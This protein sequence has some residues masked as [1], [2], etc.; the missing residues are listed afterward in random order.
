[1]SVSHI[2]VLLAETVDALQVQDGGCYVDGT[3]GRGGYTRAIL[4]AADCSV[5]AIDQDPDAIAFGQSLK[6][7]FGDRLILIQGRFGEMDSL[8]RQATAAPIDGVALDIGVSSPQLDS[9]ERGFSFRQDGPLDMRMSASGPTAAD[10]VNT[11]KETELSTIIFRLGEERAARRIAKAI[12]KARGAQPITRTVQLAEIVRSVLP[13]QRAGEND[14][15]TRTFQALRIHVNREL[16][17][18]D[19]GLRSAERLLRAGGRLA[20]VSFH[21]LEDR[22]VKRF[23]RSRSEEAP[24]GSRHRPDSG[25]RRAPTF[26]LL[27]R[28]AIAPSPAEVAANPRARS[29]RL[30][31]A[32]RTDAPSW[33]DDLNDGSW[34]D[35]A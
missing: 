17:E 15:A 12:V 2:P 32:E 13:K 10:V 24:R 16:E 25:D 30:R 29:A 1:M 20:V 28:R 18:L 35:A 26:R 31:A 33:P 5:T 7:T 34:G 22:R 14:P 21:S 3:F 4:E 19:N 27:H 8:V 9:P 11:T 6:A 23:M